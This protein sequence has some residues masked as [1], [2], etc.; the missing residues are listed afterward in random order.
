MLRVARIALVCAA[1]SCGGNVVIDGPADGGAG[2]ACQT[3]CPKIVA[4]CP[5]ATVDCAAKC[6]QL[7][8][9]QVSGACSAQVDALLSCLDRTPAFVCSSSS[10]AC[11]TETTVFS[12]CSATYCGA[13]PSICAP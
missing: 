5:G 13:N 10:Q 2:L 8:A 12:D 1:A 7:D 3:V 4:A 11:T 9:L 6:A